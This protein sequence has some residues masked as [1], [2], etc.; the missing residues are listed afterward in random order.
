M[1]I[2]DKERAR[3]RKKMLMLL[4]GTAIGGAALV[5]LA[6]KFKDISPPARKSIEDVPGNVTPAISPEAVA[7]ATQRLQDEGT[8]SFV[9]SIK[10]VGKEEIGKGMDATTT[11]GLWK[12]LEDKNNARLAA[13]GVTSPFLKPLFDSPA[14]PSE[15]GLGYRVADKLGGGTA[16]M[17]ERGKQRLGK[18]PIQDILRSGEGNRPAILRELAKGVAQGK[19]VQQHK[20]R[21]LLHKLHGKIPFVTDDPSGRAAR[22]DWAGDIATK[23]TAETAARRSAIKEIMARARGKVS[24]GGDPGAMSG[25]TMQTIRKNLSKSKQRAALGNKPG[26]ALTTANATNRAHARNVGRN[27]GRKGLAALPAAFALTGILG[28]A[29]DKALNP[30]TGDAI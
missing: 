29:K 21:A 13:A 12:W 30:S 25:A 9:G 11:S 4:G 24:P 22:K 14:K 20:T 15:G 18:V 16:E 1:P 26:G 19:S 8:R 17:I 6:K 10:R 2:N 27:V 7:D 23:R 3:R 5:A 28:K